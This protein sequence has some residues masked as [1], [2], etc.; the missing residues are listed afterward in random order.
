MLAALLAQPST[1]RT[2]AL[3][4]RGAFCVRVT[5]TSAITQLPASTHVPSRR[6]LH[7]SRP[8]PAAHFDTQLLV[9]R[10]Q[11]HGMTAEQAEGLSNVLAEAIDESVRTTEAGLVPKSAQEKQRYTQN[12]DFAQL[13]SELELHEKNDLTLMKAENERLLADVERLKQRLREEITRTQ[14]GV[15]LDL[16][17][18]K[19]R[20]K[21][22]TAQQEL[23]I[24][25]V[26]TRIESEIAGLRTQIEQAKFSILQYLV[27]VATGSGALLL[28]YMR[29]MVGAVCTCV[30]LTADV[31]CMW[32]TTVM[33]CCMGG[34]G[35]APRRVRDA[36]SIDPKPPARP[37]S[38]AG[39]K[40]PS[41]H[42]RTHRRGLLESGRCSS[43]TSALLP[44]QAPTQLT[45]LL[46]R[47]ARLDLGN[48]LVQIPPVRH[49]LLALL[50][51]PVVSPC[52]ARHRPT[53]CMMRALTA[54]SETRSL[55]SGTRSSS[56]AR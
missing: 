34:A 7:A 41:A 19:G 56:P 36:L 18:D 32:C 24:K 53:H 40:C 27:G 26:D 15:R 9:E 44:T 10:L 47:E 37:A 43:L 5:L 54:R 28:A 25:E 8:S 1:S 12:V 51:Q 23:K 4:A 29:M 14:A 46:G 48:L 49:E 42:A 17:V 52:L 39:A 50:L 31:R 3:L 30:W 11:E 45:W 35:P 13:K 6:R 21:D 16:N 2:G 38:S 22:D 20:L 33:R 55:L